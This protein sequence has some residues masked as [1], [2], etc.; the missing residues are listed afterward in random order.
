MTCLV[1][2]ATNHWISVGLFDTDLAL[3]RD[4]LAPRDAFSRL[5]PLVGELLREGGRERPDWIVCARGPGSF[6]GTR[7]CVGA[8]R[9]LSQIW[10]APVFGVDSLPFYAYCCRAEFSLERLPFA[11]ML[12]GKQRRF[13]TCPVAANLPVNAYESLSMEDLDP[14]AFLEGLGQETAVYTDDPDELRSRSGREALPMAAPRARALYE[15]ACELGGRERASDWSALAP[16]YLRADPANARGM[17]T[18]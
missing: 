11:I 6:T 12:D 10:G 4:F 13:Y 14:R 7:I 8:G 9:N 5:V 17:E 16:K 18:K 2:D 3:E 15:Y 1:F